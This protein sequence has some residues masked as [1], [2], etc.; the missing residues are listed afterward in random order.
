MSEA[1]TLFGLV[2]TE[3]VALGV[4]EQ[5]VEGVRWTSFWIY[6]LVAFITLLGF[7]GFML[8]R[9]K[10]GQDEIHAFSI[11]SVR[12]SRWLFFWSFLL[13]I[14]TAYLYAY[15]QIPGQST[16]VPLPLT[17]VA[18]H[19]FQDE[20][21]GLLLFSLL[22]A[23][24]FGSGVPE[25]VNV[26]MVFDK[27]TNEGYTVSHVDGQV[28]G[29]DSKEATEGLTVSFLES[30]DYEAE[31]SNRAYVL[32]RGLPEDKK[33]RLTIYFKPRNR[34]I[35][36]DIAERARIEA[37]VRTDPKAARFFARRLASSR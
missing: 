18:P 23:E 7:I 6:L 17:D 20:Q 37:H 3:S 15:E 33:T 4:A 11:G 31:T 21:E 10:D 35:G 27:E 29:D 13:M 14:G 2:V 28:L 30:P 24:Q 12:A 26:E 8:A 25:K 22:S 1:V 9:P 19:Q 36:Q 5:G 16:R 34:D 32:L